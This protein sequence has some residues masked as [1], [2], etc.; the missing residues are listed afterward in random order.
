MISSRRGFLCSLAAT[1]SGGLRL[2]QALATTVAGATLEIRSTPATDG[3]IRLNRNENP[4]GPSPRVA[5]AIRSS[6][7]SANRYAG[8]RTTVLQASIAARHQVAS[9]RVVLGCGSTEILRA[10]CCAYLGRGKQLLQAS[11]TFGAI[12]QYARAMG[13]DVT[14][15]G[16]TP[17]FSHDLFGMLARANSST[18]L[19]YICNPNNPTASLT[20]RNDLDEFIRKLPPTSIVIIDE[21]Y[22]QFAG[23]SATYSSF[24]DSPL[25]DP[26]IVVSR[27]FS[28]V[29]GL[30]G[31][32]VGYAVA[33][34][35]VAERLR[36]FLTE[37]NINSLAAE[38]ALAALDEVGAVNDF[39]QRNASARQEFFNQAMARALKPIDSHANFVM[40]DTLHPANEVVRQFHAGQILI[41]PSFP[42]MKTHIRVSLGS[43]EDMLAFWRAW[44]A[45]PYPK[46]TMHH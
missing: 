29:Y 11:P 43:P 45:L 30:A 14:R 26:R 41:G 1:A 24:L 34:P 33:A 46:H 35:V 4:Y 2:R 27:T 44:D 39:V 23:H 38:A 19:V 18:A 28:K 15:V 42:E 8:T 17:A 3:F 9:E 6:V 21:A 20:P 37:D 36:A 10:A 5:E 40:M 32:R 7:A 22:H 12:E 13:A 16:L 25:D 31:L